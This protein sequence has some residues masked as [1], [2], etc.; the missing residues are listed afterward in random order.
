MGTTAPIIQEIASC[1]LWHAALSHGIVN[2]EEYCV[3]KEYKDCSALHSGANPNMKNTV[4]DIIDYTAPF[5]DVESFVSLARTSTRFR[6]RIPFLITE[7][8]Y[9]T[10][11]SKND[12]I[13]KRVTALKN[14]ITAN[15]FQS[16]V[17][18]ELKFAKLLELLVSY[19]RSLRTL[20]RR[21]R[22][23]TCAELLKRDLLGV[24][25]NKLFTSDKYALKLKGGDGKLLI[26]YTRSRSDILRSE[27]G[28]AKTEYATV[29]SVLYNL[30]LEPLYDSHGF[31]SMDPVTGR[32]IREMTYNPLFEILKTNVESGK[33]TWL[34]TT[35]ICQKIG[36]IAVEE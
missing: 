35:V 7:H 30:F 13:R 17:D 27:A 28:L 5:L 36:K 6:A 26:D 24:F 2:V 21:S 20:L 12:N 19:V 31:F 14:S 8:V 29:A 10:E 18:C 15:E 9:N 22:K 3:R 25:K 4:Y 11:L 23:E 1:C 16:L 32:C 34:E 33:I